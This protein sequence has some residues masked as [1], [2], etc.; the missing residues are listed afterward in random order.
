[1]CLNSYP[2]PGCDSAGNEVCGSDSSGGSRE[3]SICSIS[4]PAN[5]A[6]QIRIV[7]TASPFLNISLVKFFIFLFCQFSSR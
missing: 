1:M 3:P 2:M 6:P 7:K 5:P 4:D